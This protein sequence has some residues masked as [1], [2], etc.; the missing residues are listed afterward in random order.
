MTG[1]LAWRQAT[2]MQGGMLEQG[3]TPQKPQW[4]FCYGCTPS[5][6]HLVRWQRWAFLPIPP[7]SQGEGA[8]C[9]WSRSEWER[10][11]LS[12]VSFG[13]CSHVHMYW[14]SSGSS[15]GH[16]RVAFTPGAKRTDAASAKES[17]DEAE[18]VTSQAR[19]GPSRVAVMLQG[20]PSYPGKLLLWRQLGPS[21]FVEDVE[22]G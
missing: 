13:S 3:N 1:L 21:H 17:R 16:H 22:E 15:A 18:H 2:G 9:S 5:F 8:A 19:N 4:G 12:R 6:Q 20:D 10:I 11:A 7:S 14:E